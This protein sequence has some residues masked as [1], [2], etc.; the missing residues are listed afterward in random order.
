MQLVHVSSR[1]TT[2]SRANPTSKASTDRQDD[3]DDAGEDDNGGRPVLIASD[4]DVTLDASTRRRRR[5][6]HHPSR[7]RRLSD[8]S[9]SCL[10]VQ[11]KLRISRPGQLRILSILFV[12][13]FLRQSFCL[14]QFT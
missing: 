1:A 6:R 7:R 13:N 10:I 11:F 12:K 9:S 5:R 2:A 3:D 4:N 14:L 8:L